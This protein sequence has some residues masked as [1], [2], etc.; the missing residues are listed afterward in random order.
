[1]VAGLSGVTMAG[2][3]RPVEMERGLKLEPVQTQGPQ[4]VGTHALDQ[5][6]YRRDVT[7]RNAQV[8][9]YDYTTTQYTF[10]YIFLLN[11]IALIL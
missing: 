1:M 9:L 6:C 5:R 8:T 2:A 10:L 11:L 7:S 4:M 3:H